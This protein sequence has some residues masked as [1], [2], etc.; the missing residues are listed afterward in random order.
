MA[1]EA[2]VFTP[3][4]PDDTDEVVNYVAAMRLGLE[5]IADGP[6]SVDLLRAMHRRLFEG[7]GGDQRTAGELRVNELRI[8]AP[9]SRIE[10]AVFVPPPPSEVRPALEALET[11]LQ[12]DSPD[13]PPLVRI[14]LAH[15]RFETIHP[16]RDGNGRIG[17]LLITLLLCRDRILTKPVL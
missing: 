5:A 1:A 16:F 13:L 9:G 12:A 11:D 15:A 6:I 8:G 10:E 2:R 3:G 17:R 7:T 14:A 4:R